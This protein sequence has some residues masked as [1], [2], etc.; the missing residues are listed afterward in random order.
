MLHTSYE[1]NKHSLIQRTVAN[2]DIPAV[3]IPACRLDFRIIT[4][5]K[6]DTYKAAQEAAQCCHLDSLGPEMPRPQPLATRPLMH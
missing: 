3:F 2:T 1:I 4:C 6:G 5:S